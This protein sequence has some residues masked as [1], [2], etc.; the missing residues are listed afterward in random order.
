MDNHQWIPPKKCVGP[1]QIGAILGLNRWKDAKTLRYELEHGHY[2]EIKP[3][4]TFG[5]EH[6]KTAIEF[7]TGH[8]SNKVA[9]AAFKRAFGGRL[10]GIADGLIDRY[11]GL[12][13]KCHMNGRAL[14]NIPD[15]YLVQVV[16]YMFLYKRSW[17]HFMSCGFDCSDETNPKLVKCHIH[18]IYW[19]NHS[20]KWYN[21]WYPQIKKF[22]NDVNWST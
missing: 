8:T 21:D 15:N 4:M 1:S 2:Q 14:G 13:V 22:I 5:Q 11:G 16:A 3:C 7:Y 10:V 17:W 19:K 6:E 20:D 9:K 18:K 12:E